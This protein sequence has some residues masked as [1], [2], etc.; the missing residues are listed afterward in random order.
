MNN[1]YI[2]KTKLAILNELFWT[3]LVVK[4]LFMG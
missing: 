3:K 4:E 1:D 2:N